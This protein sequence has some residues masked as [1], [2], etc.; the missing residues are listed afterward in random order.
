[1]CC[2]NTID[3]QDA[4]A[5][6]A[7][8]LQNIILASDFQVRDREGTAA[9]KWPMKKHGFVDKPITHCFSKEGSAFCSLLQREMG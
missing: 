8:E 1:M 7:E 9:H 5:E 2:I 3:E 6:G 4:E